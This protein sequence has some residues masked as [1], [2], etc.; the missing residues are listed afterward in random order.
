MKNLDPHAFVT[1]QYAA[2][3]LNVS[4]SYIEKLLNEKEIPYYEIDDGECLIE[5]KDLVLYKE[6][7]IDEQTKALD[8]LTKQSQEI[9]L[10]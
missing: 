6:K 5:F 10:Y 3:F 8:E 1:V 4:E 9:G 7:L 2:D